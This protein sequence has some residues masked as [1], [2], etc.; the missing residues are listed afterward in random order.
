MNFRRLFDIFPYQQAIYPQKI[1]LAHREGLKWKKYNTA[2]CLN[3]INK[4]SAGLL[5]L[6][7]N[8]NDKV[9]LIF[10][11]GNAYWNFLDFGM[12]QIG[13]VV[14]P[15]HSAIGEKE[16]EF[17]LKDSEVKFCITSSKELYEKVEKVF[18][19]ILNLKKIFC[20]EEINNVS[21]WSMLAK[22]P[23]DKHLEDFQGFKAAIHEDDLATIIYTSG[24][25]GVPKGVMLSHKNIVSNIKATLSLVPINRDKRAISFLPL[26]HIFERMVSYAYI[27]AGASVYY[28]DKRVNL[29]DYAKEVRPHYFA[30]VPRFL[31]K[32]YDGI[33]ERT[34]KMNRLKKGM[35]LW[36]IAFGERYDGKKGLSPL[37]F[38]K[39]KIADLL[40]YRSWRMALGNRVEGVVVGAAALQPKL[41]RLFSAAG[42]EIREGYGLTETSPVI[43]FNRFEPGGVRFGTVGIPVPGVQ[44]KID[45]PND[46]GEGEIIVKG[47][48]VMLGY[49]NNPELTAQV[50]DETGWFHT[51]DV[52]KIVHKRF[53]K[54]TDRKKDIF[55]TTTGKFVS[56]QTIENLLNDSP[57]IEQSMIVGF[58]RP[59]V[60][61]LIVPVFSM[62]KKWCEENKV[63]WTAEQYM[64]I[65]PKVV[66]HFEQIIESINNELTNQEKIRK[67]T[68]LYEDWSV[69]NGEITPT[70][71]LR[72][73][74]L[75]EKHLSEIEEMYKNTGV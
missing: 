40:V 54:I 35:L 62:L 67:F 18:E 61:V 20:L 28:V 37:Y 4:V 47:P 63:H 65:N 70:L 41:G 7:L 13:V 14:V 12:Q 69:E 36:A 59:F 6:G 71:K 3:Q 31:E 44:L 72:R 39:L 34:N 24:S 23:T 52:G 26:S 15:I 2:D 42:I 45:H 10:E 16:L 19:N 75:L 50:L 43:S 11:Q 1:A 27:A 17:I 53:L 21:G 68:L 66:R 46:E 9:A 56:P 49:Y 8:R 51:G 5:D 29:I 74:Y 73:P 32:F 64:V 30:S 60:A 55:K 25:S 58:N 33:L 48:G 38:L 57:F 22:E